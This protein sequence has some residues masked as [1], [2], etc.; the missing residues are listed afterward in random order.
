MVKHYITLL[1]LSGL[2][3]VIDAKPTIAAEW[4]GS[5]DLE[6]RHF[7][8]DPLDPR[9]SSHYLSMSAEPEFNHE[10][11]DGRDLLS[12]KSFF[13]YDD[14]DRE[15][16]HIDLRELMWTHAADYWELRLGVGKVFW[17]V[18][19]AAHLVDVINQTDFVENSDGEDK[20]GQP[21]LNLT[22]IRDWGNLDVFLLPGF[23]ER[24]FAGSS[25][26]PAGRPRV[27]TDLSEYRS[28][29]EDG[30]LDAAIRW[31]HT[32]GDFDVGLSHFYGTRREPIFQVRPQDEIGGSGDSSSID[33]VLL[34]PFYDVVDQTGI[35]V[36][37]TLDNILWKGEAIRQSGSS[38]VVAMSSK[39]WWAAAFGFEYTFYGAFES[40]VDVGVLVEYLHDSRGAAA[41]FNND[42]LVASRLAFNDAAGT[43]V[44]IGSIM[45]V[46]GDGQSYNFEASRRIGNNWRLYAE[47]RVLSGLS[48]NNLLY[49]LRKDDYLQLTLGYFF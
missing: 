39:R 43:E 44:L 48:E 24:T 2:G 7:F 6:Y 33:S 27:A 25:G 18:T 10:W 5:F 41:A 26:R 16:S 17:G 35:D 49:S 40:A 37:A 32:V 9:Q 38:D 1:V 29:A 46:D 8:S 13:R 23:R 28:A 42:V 20:L 22:F 21:M 19:E 14:R 30:R 36:Q 15:R 47:A 3:L 45:D 4:R 12:F 11:N 31:S 34:V